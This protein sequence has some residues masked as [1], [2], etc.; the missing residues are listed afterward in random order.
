[1]GLRE[2]RKHKEALRRPHVV[3]TI[4]SCGTSPTPPFLTGEKSCPL[5]ELPVGQTPGDQLHIRSIGI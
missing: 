4:L 3:W 5:L 2:Q 1:M